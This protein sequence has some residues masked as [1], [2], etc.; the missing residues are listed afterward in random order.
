M[1]RKRPIAS[2]PPHPSSSLLSR[3]SVLFCLVLVYRPSQ[4]LAPAIGGCPAAGSVGEENQCSW[5]EAARG[6]PAA[7][8][9]YPRA[10]L[11]SARGG[12]G[13]GAAGSEGQARVWRQVDA[14]RLA[15]GGAALVREETSS[16]SQHTLY[17]PCLS[18]AVSVKDIKSVDS[19]MI[20]ISTLLQPG[21]SRKSTSSAKEDSVRFTRGYSAE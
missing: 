21:I 10:A 3:S 16:F 13:C 2:P 5:E 11:R 14:R 18:V 4:P 12:S 19:I 6:R 8:R 7:T 9:T 20:Y 15:G 17:S 1:G